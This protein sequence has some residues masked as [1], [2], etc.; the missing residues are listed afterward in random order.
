[1]ELPWG[2]RRQWEDSE[3]NMKLLLRRLG[4]DRAG[5]AQVAGRMRARLP[6]GGRPG[7][8]APSLRAERRGLH[9]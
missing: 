8:R 7:A 6:A 5:L 4:L 9:V 1:M 3:R 2:L